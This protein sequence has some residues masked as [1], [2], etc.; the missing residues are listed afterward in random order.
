MYSWNQYKNLNENRN[1]NESVVLKKY[2]IYLGKLQL[3]EFLKN[4]IDG[5]DVQIVE[6]ETFFLLQENGDYLLQEN[7]SKI[8]LE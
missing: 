8:R 3:E 1:L 2:H 6:A 5:G 4:P 7:N